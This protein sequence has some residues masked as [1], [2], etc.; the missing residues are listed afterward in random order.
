MTIRD[1]GGPLGELRYLYVGTSRFDDDVAYYGGVLGAETVWS[2]EKFG[3]RVAAFRVAAGPLVLIADHR[4]APSC[5]PVFGVADLEATVKEL[6]ARGWTPEAGPFE[7]P[8][9]PCYTFRD[10]SGNQ[11]ALLGNERPDAL[12]AVSRGKTR[13]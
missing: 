1:A 10:P 4:P 6:R 12:M 2:F 8:D 7:I 3:A 13:G 11:I 9:G 5:M